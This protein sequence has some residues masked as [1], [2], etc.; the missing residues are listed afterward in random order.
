M[1]KKDDRQSY[2][3]AVTDVRKQITRAVVGKLESRGITWNSESDPVRINAIQEIEQLLKPKVYD[4]APK[5]LT[6]E[7]LDSIWAEVK[8]Q[9]NANL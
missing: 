1:I 9:I 5:T 2:L 4:S 6:K 3:D 8:G 7:Q